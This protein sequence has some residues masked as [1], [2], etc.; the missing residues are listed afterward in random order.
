MDPRIR[1]HTKMSWIR[2]TACRGIPIAPSRRMLETLLLDEDS[3]LLTWS[4]ST[5]LPIFNAVLCNFLSCF[6]SDFFFF[7]IRLFPL[8]FLQSF[9]VLNIFCFS[10]F[11]GKLVPWLC[12]SHN[13]TVSSQSVLAYLW[14]RFSG[15]G[16]CLVL[17][18]SS[19]PLTYP[20]F[21]LHRNR[22]V[23]TRCSSS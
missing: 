1:I 20:S 19:N 22:K 12:H 23:S 16:A 10:G 17:T 5:V 4:I 13:E 6:S 11:S 18:V 2:N 15:S 3:L 7:C 14:T 9:E 8:V 21:L